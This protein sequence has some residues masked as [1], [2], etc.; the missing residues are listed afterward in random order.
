MT[1][2]R[3]ELIYFFKFNANDGGLNFIKTAVVADFLMIVTLRAAVIAQHFY[4][5]GN[6]FAF[7]DDHA[8]IAVTARFLLGKKLKQPTSPIVPTFFPYI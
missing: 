2:R 8:A 1:A 5:P 6:F 3:V 7:R 4:L